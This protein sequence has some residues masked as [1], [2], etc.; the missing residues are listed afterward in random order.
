M[1]LIRA[2]YDSYFCCRPGTITLEMFTGLDLLP[3]FM[4]ALEG[5][6]CGEGNSLQDAG[7]N[8]F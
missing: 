2:P 8:T 5:R 4:F 7:A 3:P 1:E 6:V